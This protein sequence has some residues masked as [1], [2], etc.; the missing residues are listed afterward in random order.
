MIVVDCETTGLDCL[1]NSIV[2]IGA[3]DFLNPSKQFYQECRIWDGAEIEQ[4]ALDINGFLKEQIIDKNKKSLDF[5]IRE[6]I[7]WAMNC[8]DRILGGEN[9]SFDRDFLKSSAER[10]GIAWPFG[11]R[12]IDLHSLCY[13]SILYRGLIPP[14]KNNKSDLDLDKILTYVGL[15]PEPRPHHALTGAKMEAEAFSRLINRKS[16]LDEFRSFIVPDY[17]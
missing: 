2:S 13:L 9:P 8:D 5:V 15:P 1:K 3:V 12:T 14:V 7:S 17:L 10:F 4:A 11:Y 16:L 6:F